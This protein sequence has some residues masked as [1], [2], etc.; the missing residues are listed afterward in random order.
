MCILKHFVAIMH[1]V[2]S[3]GRDFP[4]GSVVKNPPA[5]ARDAR[6]VGSD[7][8][9]GRSPGGGDDNPTPIFFPGEFLGQRSL[10]GYSPWDCKELDTTEQLSTHT[11]LLFYSS[12][13]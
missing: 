3:C 7:P 1:P 5:Q 9:L 10:A 8:G 12:I 11:L 2:C 6:D 4:G 13:Y